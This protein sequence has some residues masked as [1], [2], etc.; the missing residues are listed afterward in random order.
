MAI[1]LIPSLQILIYCQVFSRDMSDFTLKKIV[2]SIF[3]VL[4]N[5]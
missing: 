5:L 3:L 1:I 2:T 4:Q